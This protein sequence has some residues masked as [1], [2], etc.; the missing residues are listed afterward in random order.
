MPENVTPAIES[1][2]LKANLQETAVEEG[3]N[4]GQ[5]TFYVQKK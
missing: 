2:A 3:D 1:D 4:W 5:T